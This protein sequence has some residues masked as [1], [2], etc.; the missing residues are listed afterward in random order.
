MNVETKTRECIASITLDEGS[1]IRRSEE[2]ERERAT[3]IA[4][5]LARNHFK[6]HCVQEGPYEVYLSIKDNSLLIRITSDTLTEAR[7]V[8]LPIKPF[9]GIVKD[10]FIMVESYL[11]AVNGG[12][13]HR[14][15]AIDMARRGVHNEGSE[16]L[17]NQLDGRITLDFDTARRLFTL[18]CVL[19][20]R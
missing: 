5:L 1:I 2:V 16:L 17:Q 11:A 3:A 20:I 9:K 19:H 18:I 15:E 7:D 4:D 13:P 14:V 12:E 10:Y 6:P 8:I